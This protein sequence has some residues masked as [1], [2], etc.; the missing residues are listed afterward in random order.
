MNE[1]EDIKIEGI[2]EITKKVLEELEVEGIDKK[3]NKRNINWTVGPIVFRLLSNIEAKW[4][5]TL[6]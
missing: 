6:F 1:T 4:K 3:R 2:R 5:I